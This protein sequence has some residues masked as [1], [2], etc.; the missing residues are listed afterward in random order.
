MACMGTMLSVMLM[1][2]NECLQAELKNDFHMRNL[3]DLSAIPLAIRIIKVKHE[4]ICKKSRST[5]NYNKLIG[6]I[7][8]LSGR[9]TSNFYNFIVNKLC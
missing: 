3:K 6:H 8:S 1:Y 5:S 9:H 2:A 4:T 7:M